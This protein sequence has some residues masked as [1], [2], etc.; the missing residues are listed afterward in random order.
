M[1]APEQITTVEELEALP[2]GSVVQDDVGQVCQRIDSAG[3]WWRATGIE[4]TPAMYVVLNR[5]PLTVLWRPDRPV[6]PSASA[7]MV[8]GEMQVV[9]DGVAGHMDSWAYEEM[10]K[11]LGYVLT[12][13]PSAVPVG[14]SIE[15]VASD[16]R[17]LRDAILA[18]GVTLTVG[19]SV[20]DAPSVA[21]TPEQVEA[22]ADCLVRVQAARL[23]GFDVGLDSLDPESRENALGD[24]RAVHAILAEGEKA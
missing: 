11:A 23:D 9:L 8:H 12:L 4:P 18:T 7:R 2:N 22:A 19:P 10:R 3:G 17:E 21:V 5:A 13:E 1:T 15:D 14:P 24:V 6:G 16:A 20:V